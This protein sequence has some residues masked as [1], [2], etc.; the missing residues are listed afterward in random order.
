VERTVSTALAAGREDGAT[1]DR[2]KASLPSVMM[3]QGLLT[4]AMVARALKAQRSTGM[5]IGQQLQA[6]GI[7]T[8]QQVLNALAAQAGVRPVTGIDRERLRSAPGGL[9]PAIVRALGVVPFQAHAARRRLD[10]A[11]TAPI[12]WEAVQAIG[13]LTGWQVTAFVVT[14]QE[15]PVLLDSYG[16]AG[17][18]EPVRVRS[19]EEA[20]TRIAT[21][22]ARVGALRMAHARCHEFVLVRLEAAGL[23]QDLIC[24]GDAGVRE[25]VGAG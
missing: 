24:G 4:A 10:V 1:A 6:M 20:A 19:V 17:V 2:K 25:V 13:D 18:G 21:P 3:H 15:M 16:S 23:N 11:A 7:A 14:D 22:A 12:P 8:E 5:R 9:S